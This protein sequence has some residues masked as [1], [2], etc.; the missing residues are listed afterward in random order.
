MQIMESKILVVFM[1]GLF[2]F[3]FNSISSKS[4][5]LRDELPYNV[6]DRYENCNT[7]E[8]FIDKI[9]SPPPIASIGTYDVTVK[10]TSINYS[11]S[12]ITFKAI[13][14]IYKIIP[15]EDILIWQCSS[16]PPNHWNMSFNS[17]IIKT[18][19]YPWTINQPGSYRINI[20][21]MEWPPWCG[22]TYLN[23]SIQILN[24]PVVY[25]DDNFN[26]SIPGWNTTYFNKIQDGIDAV[27]ENGT[28]YVYNGI[29]YENLVINKTVDMIGENKNTTI[30]NGDSSND[31]IAVNDDGVNISC[32]TIS[33]IGC[34]FPTSGINVKSN[35][36]C[37]N[38]NRIISTTNGITL[39]QSSHNIISKNSII[40][41][42]NNGIEI[43]ESSNSS[44]LY[45]KFEN[46]ILGISFFDGSLNNTISDNSYEDGEIFI[47]LYD[48]SGNYI[49]NNSISGSNIGIWLR[50]SI[51]NIIESNTIT[52][53]NNPIII[54]N[55]SDNNSIYQNR[56]LNNNRN[57]KDKCNNFWDNGYPSG[58]NYWDDYT[59]TDTDGDGIGDTPY[60]IDGGINQD[61][62]PLGY[63]NSIVN[64]TYSPIIPNAGELVQ[65]NSTSFDPD[66]IIT[67]WLWDFDDGNT[68]S[69][70]NT[71]H[72]FTSNGT[73]TVTL[74]VTNEDGDS[75]SHSKLIPVGLD[76]Y[77][78]QEL[79]K[80]W[81]FISLPF[82]ESIDKDDL[83]LKHGSYYYDIGY[84]FGWNRLVQSYE[85]ADMLYQGYGYWLYSQ[86][87][88]ELWIV[89]I[90][91]DYDSYI[92]TV[93]EGWNVMGVPY[94][95]LVDKTDV[96]VDDVPWNTA[97]SNGWISD[98]V[99]DWD[100]PGQ[101]YVFSDSLI[102]TE[103]YWL[104]AYQNC[105]LKRNI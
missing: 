79:F 47:D 59:G 80:G 28:V 100:E 88:G 61:R 69:T 34:P 49:S 68:N 71:T 22:M 102:P 36:N 13:A 42:W 11:S 63:F 12:N 56:F 99:F 75:N 32:F 25:V 38:K 20:T 44:I 3:T 53:S 29:Y 1:I 104:Y 46:S 51:D 8:I 40:S 73:Y 48:S 39:Q 37:I 92:T 9:I 98:F 67:S 85:F 96:L 27:A 83:L 45:N 31:V 93:E 7:T 2:I 18:F 76:L 64:Y 52:L 50:Y 19:I 105:I 26:S 95:D 70:E 24:S 78:L 86:E 43:V 82:N 54:E 101:T 35:N 6:S 87:D 74:T 91:M 30:I 14:D 66:G 89:D 55:S 41:S 17:S 62:Y 57:C 5:T 72:S 4:N 23:Q 33:D 90:H 103:A 21:I 94:Y 16:I 77:F 81:N 10:L 97:V 65:F 60:N 58:G 15:G 84:L